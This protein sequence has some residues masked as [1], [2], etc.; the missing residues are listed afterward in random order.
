MTGGCA[1]IY[2]IDDDNGCQTE[3]ED[4]GYLQ[5]REHNNWVANSNLAYD[6]TDDICKVRLIA[7]ESWVR[8]E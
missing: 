2:L 3:N 4:N 7:K 5:A 1:M 6:L 8:F